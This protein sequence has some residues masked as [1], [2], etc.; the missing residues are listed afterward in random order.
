MQ[1]RIALTT[2]L[3][4]ALGACGSA[5]S[6][7]T[8][9]SG[10]SEQGNQPDAQRDGARFE[11]ST[12]D[13]RLP[14]LGERDSGTLADQ[15]TPPDGPT[16]PWP[17]EDCAKY[18]FSATTL[19]AERVGFG[20][21]TKGG[22]P[23]NVVH[24]KNTNA[25]GTGSLRAALESSASSWIV[26]DVKK[27]TIKIGTVHLKSNK[28]IDGRGR[29]ITIEGSLR[30]DAGVH[31]IIISDV[32][33][34]NP[35]GDD[36]L[37]IGGDVSESPS[38]LST[39]NFFFHHLELFTAKDGLLDVKHAATNLTLSW[40]HL[41]SHV[42]ALLVASDGDYPTVD[43]A[44]RLTY[45]HNF[46]DRITRRGPRIR[47]G[48]AD[49]FNNYQYQWYEY[50]AGSFSG[51]QLLSQNNVYE[52]R[53]GAFCLPACPDPNPGSDANDFF[54]SKN[55]LIVDWANMGL[56]YTKSVGD[57]ALEG[58]VIVQ[59]EPLKVFDRA[60]YYS[61]TPEPAG[62]QLVAKIKAGA[63]PRVGYCQTP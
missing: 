19:L 61:A 1:H 9:D 62:P 26:F 3:A 4:F 58:A 34:T 13:Q 49:Y 57:V 52:A 63:G 25:S 51:A 29:D 15:A 27:G 32:R 14:E 60:T 16:S 5:A 24:V 40:T 31:D 54:V 12:A 33:M 7:P 45:H 53:P 28:T 47:F 43:A 42:K 23:K 6:A 39:K 22:D 11:A 59:N 18:P 38:N 35:N 55:A 21:Q 37:T 41:H 20:G 46:F 36:V 50:G 17:G 30:I 8:A 48:K 56:G 44:M 10:R 2:I